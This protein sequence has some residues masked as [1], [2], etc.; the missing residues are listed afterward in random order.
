M[1]NLAYL[2]NEQL[3]PNLAYLY[4]EQLSNLSVS[5]EAGDMQ[6]CATVVRIL[7][8]DEVSWCT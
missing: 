5:I 4:N 2:Y 1:P 7:T 6:R 3:I 8:V